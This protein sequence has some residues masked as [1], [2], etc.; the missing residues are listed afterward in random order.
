MQPVGNGFSWVLV[1]NLN[2][3]LEWFGLEKALKLI[4]FYTP[5]MGGGTFYWTRLLQPDLERFQGWDR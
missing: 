2:R 5:A 1:A 4:L 3:I